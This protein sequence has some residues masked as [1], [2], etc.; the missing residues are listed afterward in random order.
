MMNKIIRFPGTPGEEIEDEALKMERYAILM[1]FPDD[2]KIPTH[3]LAEQWQ[4]TL[5]GVASLIGGAKRSTSDGAFAKMLRRYG[6]DPAKTPSWFGC[7]GKSVDANSGDGVQNAKDAAPHGK[8]GILGVD[9]RRNGGADGKNGEGDG[10]KLIFI[11]LPPTLGEGEFREQKTPTSTPTLSTSLGHQTV[12][13]SP[14]PTSFSSQQLASLSQQGIRY[15]Q[16]HNAWV[17]TVQMGNGVYSER[18]NPWEV[19][20]QLEAE[21]QAEQTRSSLEK[22][23]VEGL[24]ESVK[25]N[26]QAIL[27]KVAL[28]PSVYQCFQYVSNVR[29]LESGRVLFGGDFGDY[30]SYCVLYATRNIYGVEPSFIVDLPSLYTQHKKERQYKRVQ[31]QLPFRQQ[32]NPGGK[33]NQGTRIGASFL[34][35]HYVADEDE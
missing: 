11:A 32:A 34:P 10:K 26:T 28:N 23:I 14:S 31:P 1:T 6:Y 3:E 4:I 8:D 12:N 35:H 19:L 25:V 24:L 17:K 2:E 33:L 5:P 16:E 9:I 18:V 7:S 15:Y 21:I 30:I 29:D 13:S 20:S 22:D 27:R